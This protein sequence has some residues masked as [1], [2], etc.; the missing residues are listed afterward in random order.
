MPNIALPRREFLKGAASGLAG[1]GAAA[2]MAN[3]AGPAP[4]GVVTQAHADEAATAATGNP[5]WEV[6]NTELLVIG[7]GSGATWAT[8]RALERGKQVLMVEKGPFRHAGASSMSWDAWMLWWDYCGFRHDGWML[9]DGTIPLA[10][11]SYLG[12]NEFNPWVSSINHGQTLVWRDE[13][14]LPKPETEVLP[15]SVCSSFYRRE[16][17]DL[18]DKGRVEVMDQT[19]ITDLLVTD[20]RCVG[21]MGIHLPTGKTRVIRA[22]AT[23]MAAGGGTQFHGW[24]SV[25][26]RGINSTDNTGDVAMAA[27]R[28]GATIGEAEF[29][30]YD[31][32]SIVYEDVAHTFGCGIGADAGELE[33]LY[34]ADHERIFA[35]GEQVNGNLGMSQRIGRLV[36]EEGKGTEHDGVYVHYDEHSF[37]NVR[38]PIMRNVAFF[39]EHGYDPIGKFTE[40][41]AEMYEHGGEPVIDATMMTEWQGLFDERGAGACGENGG[42]HC[43]HNRLYGSY[44][45]ECACNYLDA[46]AEAGDTGARIDWDEVAREHARLV[47]IRT[48]TCEDGLRPIEI[49]R[50]IQ[51]AGYRGFTIY[52]STEMMEEAIAELERIRTEDM[53]K[54]VL[55]DDSTTF[56]VDWKTAIENYNLLDCAE[57]SIRASLLREET[58]GCYLRPEF[59]ERDD[60]NWN[61]MLACH[62][63]N[64]EM[65]F[66]KRPYPPLEA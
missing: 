4:L 21:A 49:R 46:L 1:A 63:E 44:T 39:Q 65:V 2:A 13:N 56:N 18:L 53:P 6:F 38:Y 52:R 22:T 25:G 51:A 64:G 20:G 47:E 27:F 36:F 59:P 45:G 12:G 5:D 11:W 60:E 55:A 40:V 37:D 19:I 7:T 9:I 33:I 62:L 54:Q 50:K 14:G 8:Q 16:A 10:A 43:M 41:A 30:Q 58:R 61:C 57:V 35:D 29:A 42:P 24:L 17:D 23:I 28:K 48:R 32:N 26:Y 3:L 66:E 34:D 31:Y 15:W